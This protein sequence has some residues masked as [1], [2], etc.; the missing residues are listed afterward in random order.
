MKVHHEIIHLYFS[1]KHEVSITGKKDLV[2]VSVP[3]HLEDT[4]LEL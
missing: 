1:F 4:P 2:V 3:L